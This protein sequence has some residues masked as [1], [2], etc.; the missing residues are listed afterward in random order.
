MQ[1]VIT[2]F[3]A[4]TRRWAINRWIREF[5]NIE[6]DPALTNLC[7]IVDCDEPYIE[8]QLKKTFQYGYRSFHVRINPANQPNEIKLAIR[9]ARVADVKNQSKDLIAKT[10]GEYII[11]FEDDTVMERLDSLATLYN[12]LDEVV[13]FVEGVQMGRWGANIIGAWEADNPGMPEVIKTL[14]PPA[15]PDIVYQRITGGGFYGYATHRHLYLNHD[16]YTSTSQPWGPDVNFGFYVRSRGY[17]CY[18]DW[19]TIFGHADHDRIGWPD[20]P[21]QKLAQV[22]YTKDTLTGKWNRTDHEETR[23]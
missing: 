20:T 5:I 15:N 3:C 22:V 2:V 7:F 18:I 16:Y 10:D 14:L 9:R 19:S 23:Y 4:F 1:P 8:N 13:G 17:N 12:G 6:H 21:G 11:S